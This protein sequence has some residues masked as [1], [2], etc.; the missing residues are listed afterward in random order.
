MSLTDS[1][2]TSSHPRVDVLGV[3][4]SAITMD[5]AVATIERWIADRDQHYVCVTTVH[6][7]ME[8]QDDDAFRSIL[9]DS[10]MTTPDGMPLVWL[11]H[12]AG[13]SRVSRVYGPDLLLSMCD[14][15]ARRGYRFFLYGADEGV[16][17]AL[18]A[19]LQTQFPGLIIAGT[20][21]PPF[22]ALSPAEDAEVV[23]FIRSSKPDVVW[24]GLGTPKQERWMADHAMQIGAVL[25]GVGAAFDF[26]SGRKKQAPEW[27]RRNGLE[28]LFRLAQE[29]KRLWK[30]YLVLNTRFVVGLLLRGI[31]GHSKHG[32]AF[33]GE[34]NK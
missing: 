4:V 24:V 12:H 7:V 27:M 5:D 18:A 32:D 29:P 1:S 21:T 17:P 13:F 2:Q 31:G 3:G 6:G 9:N 14:V 10:G 34:H 30:R 11:A 20:W 26:H 28:W 33:A 22:R 15:A 16:A 25:I 8:A 19:R 23:D